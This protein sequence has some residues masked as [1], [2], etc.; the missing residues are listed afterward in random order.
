MAIETTLISADQQT[1]PRPFATEAPGQQASRATSPTRARAQNTGPLERGLGWFSIGLGTAQLLMPRGVA[2]LAGIRED[3]DALI[4]LCGLRELACG[5]G[6][7][8]QPQ[9]GPWI[10]ARVVGD[11]ADL[12]MLGLALVSP[13]NSRGRTS[14]AFAA[15]AAVTALDVICSRELDR[16]RGS[17]GAL[18]YGVPVE[19][20]VTVNRSAEEC[21]TFWRNLENLPRFMRHL[22]SVEAI[23]ERRSHWVAKAPAGTTVEWDAEI[24]EDRPNQ[25]LAWR[26]LEGS[27]IPNSGTVRFEPAPPGRGTIL[28]VSM[29]YD[30]PAGQLGAAVAKLFGEEPQQQVADDLRRFKQLLETGEIP[31]TV[32]QSAGK[33]SAIGRLLRKGDRT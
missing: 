14:A 20:V 26:T 22:E 23:D 19:K 4:R 9:P 6:I 31:T 5:I 13:R 29:Q 11:V 2:R 28:R 21:Y 33:R 16:G 27:D 32:G 10:K 1:R 24:T 3:H 18:L 17:R 25:M 30:P 8:T 15:V 12:A 7:L